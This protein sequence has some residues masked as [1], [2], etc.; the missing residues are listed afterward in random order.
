MKTT[1]AYKEKNLWIAY[2]FIT[3]LGSVC[4]VGEMRE[5]LFNV[6]CGLLL[7][8]VGVVFAVRYF[9]IPSQIMVLSCD[10]CTLI[11]PKGVTVPLNS[12]KS[13]SY[14]RSG[15]GRMVQNWGSVTIY[16]YTGTYIYGFVANCEEVAK[17][18]TRLMH[19]TKKKRYKIKGKRKL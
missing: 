2:L 14:Q 6:I 11:L 7:A 4:F 10:S 13:V 12:I 1:I 3:L 16:A 17:E 9:L 18:L 8:I 15:Q 5:N 19:E